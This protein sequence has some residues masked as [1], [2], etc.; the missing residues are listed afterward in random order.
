LVPAVIEI[1]R[2]KKLKAPAATG[3][4]SLCAPAMV[5][6]Y[7]AGIGIT[8]TAPQALAAPINRK[9]VFALDQKKWGAS[10]K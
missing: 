3:A 5:K 9:I 7:S 10:H 4:F 8:H 6:R 2:D 1:R